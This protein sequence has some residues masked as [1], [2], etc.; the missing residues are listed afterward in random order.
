MIGGI[1]T[2]VEEQSASTSEIAGNIAQASQGLSEVNEN[3]AQS[4]MMSQ[5]IS[6]D[7]AAITQ[8]AS[9]VDEV[10]DQVEDNVRQLLNL[11]KQLKELMARFTL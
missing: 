6:H 9:A 4:S 5:H 2:A 3:V 7:I 8:Q 11:A 10:S 1:A